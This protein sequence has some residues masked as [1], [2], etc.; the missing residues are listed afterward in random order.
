MDYSCLSEMGTVPDV[1]AGIEHLGQ[2]SPEPGIPTT[3]RIHA[4][5]ETD[6]KVVCAYE[7]RPLD[8]AEDGRDWL[9]DIHPGSA[10][11]R[12]Y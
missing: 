7:P 5:R 3:W 2:P 12:L 1:S 6:R 10:L 4:V 8:K 11:P 9:S